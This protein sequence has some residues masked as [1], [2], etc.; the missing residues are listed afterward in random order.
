MSWPPS[1]GRTSKPVKHAQRLEAS[2]YAE[3]CQRRALQLRRKVDKAGE[4]EAMRGGTNSEAGQLLRG[5]R[6]C[7]PVSQGRSRPLCQWGPHAC[8]SPDEDNGQVETEPLVLEQAPLA[9]EA[10]GR[11]LEHQLQRKERRKDLLNSL[12]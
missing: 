11:K 1:V 2:E 3:K 4:A 10:K 5:A 9:A 12:S 8:T 7:R 6:L